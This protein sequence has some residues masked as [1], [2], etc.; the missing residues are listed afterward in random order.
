[1]RQTA[2]IFENWTLF[3]TAVVQ[4]VFPKL[5]GKQ[6]HFSVGKLRQSR[7]MLFAIYLL[8]FAQ[9]EVYITLYEGFVN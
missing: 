9:F 4:A 8:V 2:L 7:E 6:T 5:G 1:M 3:A